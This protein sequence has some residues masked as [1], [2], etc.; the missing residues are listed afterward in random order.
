MVRDTCSFP[1]LKH[2]VHARGSR[3]VLLWSFWAVAIRREFYEYTQLQTRHW[4]G[5]EKYRTTDYKTRRVIVQSCIFHRRFSASFAAAYI[6]KIH[7]W[8]RGSLSPP[9]LSFSQPCYLVCHFP[10]LCYKLLLLTSI[11]SRVRRLL[12]QRCWETWTVDLTDTDSLAA[13]LER[14]TTI[15]CL[16]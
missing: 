3:N 11:L 16:S 5:D 14:L 9:V 12:V 13:Q 8:W 4:S 7:T 1:A 6:R 15:E 10:V 2:F